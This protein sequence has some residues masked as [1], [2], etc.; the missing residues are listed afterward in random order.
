MR[1]SFAPIEMWE[2]VKNNNSN[3]DYMFYY[4]VKTTG[5]F[6]IPSCNSRTPLKDNVVY[7]RNVDEAIE[8]GFRPCKRCRPDLIGYNPEKKL[9]NEIK[10]LI[11]TEYYLLK[12][13]SS[14]SEKIGLSKTQ[15]YRLFREYLKFT[16]KEYLEKIR[17]EKACELLED[18]ILNNAEIG[19]E[20][21]FASISAF[22]AVFR[23]QT[24]CSPGEFRD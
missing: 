21:G 23:K 2:A 20:V 4:G 11:E 3:Y 22:Y 24:G 17:I 8:K 13:V 19:L 6:C 10:R 7:F 5:V 14:I 12:N 9:V 16:P 18:G 1:K 15:V